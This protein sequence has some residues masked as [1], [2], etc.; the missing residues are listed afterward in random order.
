MSA[1]LNRKLTQARERLQ[2]GDAAG[3]QALCQEVLQRAPRNPD[4]LYLLGVTHLMTGQARAALPPLRQAVVIDPRHG[5]ALENLAL[6][7]LMLGEFGDAER[8]L[9]GAAA[10]PGAPASVFMRLG[11]SILNQ[12][13]HSEAIVEIKRALALNPHDADIRL[14]L[15]QALA[16]AGESTAARRQFE[17]ALNLAPEHADAMFNLGVI[18]LDA[19]NLDAARQ[20]FERVIAQS[21]RH[22]EALVNLGIVHEQ[23]RRME[24]AIDCF[25][26]AFAI[27]PALTQA[28]NNLARALA[29][30]GKPEEAREYYLATLRIAPNLTETHDGLASACLALGR[31]KEAIV[32]LREILRA[33]PENRN[34]LNALAEALFQTG[35]LALAESTVQRVTAL[36]PAAVAPYELLAEIYL[37]RGE[38]DRAVA[39]LGSGYQRT[40][41]ASMLGKLTFLLR[42]VCDWD[43][44]REAWPALKTVLTR[45]PEAIS[46]FSLL[47][48]PTTTGEQLLHARAWSAARF[49]AGIAPPVRGAR[50]SAPGRLRIGYFSSDFYLHATAYLL[51]EVLEL[52]DRSRF[53]IFAY[54]YGPDDKSPMRTRL[55]QASEHFVDIAWDPDDVAARRIR[56]DDLDIL[57]DL[58]G[59]TMGARTG[60]LARRP[61][62]LQ[63]SWLGYPGTMG[64]HFIDCLIA[65]PF[66]IP[67][68]CEQSY[69]ERVLRLPHCYQPNDRKRAVSAP[70]TR[71]Q[72]GL[73]DE[74]VVFCCFNQA[75][76]ITPEVF[77]CWMRLLRQVAGSVLWLLDDNVSASANLKRE[78]MAHG[79]ASERIIFAPRLPLEQH[80]ARYQVTLLALDTFPYG[81]HTTASDALWGECLLVALCGETFASRVAGSILNNCHLSDLVTHDIEEYE[82][83]ALRIATDRQFRDGL[84]VRLGAARTASPLFDADGFTR[85]LEHLYSG[86]VPGSA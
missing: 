14:N 16:A 50:K 34:A 3:A 63:V 20:R 18:D 35:D 45:N 69:S 74:G 57:I 85:D 86:L 39:M 33:E 11:I 28:G 54:S 42:R 79:I 67:A 38:F 55:L 75:Y 21:P 72:Y 53:E 37:L 4:A 48:E 12:G 29:L 25:R 8:A 73:P 62:A 9:R 64:A 13:R 47:C 83:L 81:S 22:A 2:A 15:G 41:A 59:Y 26:R 10:L 24:A 7:N 19:G 31:F 32:H 27:S 76:K 71:K 77:A 1:A 70:V 84:R 68:G 44:W 36:D 5:A 43:E 6:A 52:H 65:D 60:I 30:Q 78:A 56:D 40:S 58:K 61:C 23:E 46:P 80:L 49:G 17:A 51:A 82:R 66:I